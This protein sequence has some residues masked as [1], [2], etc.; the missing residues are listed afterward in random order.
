[1]KNT[2]NILALSAIVLVFAACEKKYDWVAQQDLMDNTKAYF[3]FIHASP[4][5]RLIH[6]AQDTFHVYVNDKKI[7][8]APLTYNGMWPF[9]VN[10]STTSISAT[11]AM[12]EP[13]TNTIRLTIP[14]KDTPDSSTIFTITKDL[15]AGVRHTFLLT[16]SVKMDRDSSRIFIPDDLGE[17][18]P[19]TGYIN[20]RLIHAVMN[21]TAGKTIN[22][23]S[24]ARN[25]DIITNVKPGT[26][27]S[28][29]RFNFN[30]GVADTFYVRR[31]VQGAPP[32]STLLLAKIPF[33]AANISSG[34]LDQRSFTIYYK[35]NGDLASGTK[36]R[37]ASAYINK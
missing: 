31:Y 37:S 7:T 13:G 15:A 10:S 8:S 35:G 17:I 6:D 1:M 22:I 12:V 4:S 26:A 2:L 3:K 36:G 25:A 28:F 21:D 16:D 18:T 29:S 30:P 24:Y 32:N 20:L 23:S 33:N 27:T 11:Y 19:L 34:S 5:F 9:S 14:G